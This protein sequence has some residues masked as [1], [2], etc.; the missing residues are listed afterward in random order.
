MADEG[1][2]RPV[3]GEL[4]TSTPAATSREP[5]SDVVDA[6]FETVTPERD[7]QPLSQPSSIATTT[8]PVAGMDIL[9]GADLSAAPAGP[10]RG[11]PMFWIAGIALA[12]AAF[13]VSGGHALVRETGFLASPEATRMLAISGVT[14]R[15]DVSGPRP[16]LF[17]DGEAVN[18]GGEPQSLPS[19]DIIVTGTDGKTVRYKLGTAQKTLAP[20]ERFAFSSRLDVPKNGVKTV[21]VTFA[22]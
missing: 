9:R 7:R 11:G 12:A 5:A 1:K 18:E 15:V 16:V 4:M 17:V 3:S 22:E 8:A 14:S 2:A 6:E 21:S 13:W 10:V 20:G 19:L